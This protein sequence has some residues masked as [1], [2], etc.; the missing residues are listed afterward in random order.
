MKEP[1][2]FQRKGQK[3]SKNPLL[4]LVILICCNMMVI[5][6]ATTVSYS[7]PSPDQPALA[8]NS[9]GR[10]VP[11]P[12]AEDQQAQLRKERR[13][14][15]MNARRMEREKEAIT[16]SPEQKQKLALLLLFAGG[17]ARNIHM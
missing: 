10:I 3:K 6:L 13:I 12:V 7:F 11:V 16:L 5:T 17:Q 2:I 4:A 8:E 9:A 15:D 1:I 14:R